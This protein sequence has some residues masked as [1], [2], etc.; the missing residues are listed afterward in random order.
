M[1]PCSKNRKLIAWLAVDALDVQQA[2]DL[3]AHVENCQGCRGYL[4]E[5]SNVTKRLSAAETESNLR[6]STGFHQELVA[7]LRV[8]DRVSVWQFIASFFRATVLDW[9]IAA[10]TLGVALAV[11]FLAG[12]HH[13]V[14]AP[15]PTIR[16]AHDSKTESDPAPTLSNYQMIANKSLEELDEV[17]TRQGNRNLPRTQIYTA[18]TLP[19]GNTP[20]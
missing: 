3:R 11:L 15:A 2:R 10:P 6:A 17:L 7:R 14:S 20:D 12:R 13:N 5:I 16:V 4:E 19:R 8:E 1:K 9:R 18:S